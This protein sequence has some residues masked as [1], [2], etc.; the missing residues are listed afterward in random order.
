MSQRRK[1]IPPTQVS[2][3]S[4]Q[5][6]RSGLIAREK[7]EKQSAKGRTALDNRFHRTCL[8]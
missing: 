6:G 7:T 5:S 8:V 2:S 3:R 1:T 4:P